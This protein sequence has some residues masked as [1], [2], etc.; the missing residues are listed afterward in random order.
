GSS[1]SSGMASDSGNQGTLCT[2]EFAVQMTCQSCVDAVRK[3]LQGVAGVQ[4]V[5]VHLEDQMVLVHTT[6]PSQ[7]VQAL[8]EG[9]GRQAVLKGMGSGQLQNSGPSSG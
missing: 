8:L 9:T 3:S 7:E 2:L 1:G 5:E 6:L 4:D